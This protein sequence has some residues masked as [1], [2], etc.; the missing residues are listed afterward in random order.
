MDV[1]SEP[2]YAAGS[3]LSAEMR[4][5]WSD[6]GTLSIMM[7]AKC[8]GSAISDGARL[9]DVIRSVFINRAANCRTKASHRIGNHVWE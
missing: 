8:Q 9:Y 5:R 7:K 3:S 6:A 1:I 4:R 2:N